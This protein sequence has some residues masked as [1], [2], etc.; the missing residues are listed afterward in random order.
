MTQ[1]LK[2]MSHVAKSIASGEFSKR[3]EVKGNDEIAQLGLSLNHMAEAL[4]K[5]ENA[6][7]GEFDIIFMDIQMPVMD[8]Y[9]ATKRIRTCRH[10]DADK[11]L[12][13][14][15][16]ANAYPEDSM[17]ARNYGMNEHLPKPISQQKLIETVL[18]VLS[19][20]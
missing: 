17:R 16:T 1:P 10:P 3:I 13:V 15:M 6:D 18:K 11:I 19:K 9:E 20:N 7:P 2:G 14:A 12:I 5:F 8:G 4:E